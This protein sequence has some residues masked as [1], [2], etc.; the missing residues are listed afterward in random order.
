MTNG[1]DTLDKEM[2]HILGVTG[3]DNMRF[4]HSELCNLKLMNCLF[5][6]FSICY[7]WTT[8]DPRSL[9]LWKT[10]LQIRG[11]YWTVKIQFV[12]LK[13]LGA[14]SGLL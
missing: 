11:D 6:E 2:I 9:K 3:W 5:L 14:H 12:N 7:F 10:K 13:S 4:R 1:Q 8:V